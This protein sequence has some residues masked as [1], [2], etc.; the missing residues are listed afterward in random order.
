MG[1]MQLRGFTLI[2]LVMVILLLSIV[3][4]L[5]LPSLDTG[6]FR[7]KGFIQQATAAIRY[8]QKQAIGSGCEVDVSITAA[9]C[10]LNW[11]NPA[12]NTNCPADNTTISNPGSISTNFCANSEPAATGDLPVSFTFDRIGRP[13]AAQSMNLGNG[14]IVVEAETGYT[15][16]T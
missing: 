3:A 13:S 8:A 7:E 4:V 9:A 1:M 5:V 10:S 15:H 16:E 6:S 11:H 2:E 12:A 14:T